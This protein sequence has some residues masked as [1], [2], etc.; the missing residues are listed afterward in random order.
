MI[1]EFADKQKRNEHEI[2]NIMHTQNLGQIFEINFSQ[3]SELPYLRK[4]FSGIA[5]LTCHSATK[6]RRKMPCTK[7]CYHG[8]S[9]RDIKLEP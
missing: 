5:G 7:K 8:E 3:A 4:T 6:I 9:P 2:S 1:K